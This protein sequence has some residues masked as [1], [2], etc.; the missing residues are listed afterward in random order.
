VDVFSTGGATT[1]VSALGASSAFFLAGAFLGFTSLAGSASFNFLA[2]GAS[3]VLEAERTNSP[4]SCNLA[5]T[6][7]LS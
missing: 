4:K 5:S 2:T 7:L 6:S 3:I 1:S